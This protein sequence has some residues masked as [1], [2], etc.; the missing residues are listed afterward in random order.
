MMYE[1]KDRIRKMILEKYSDRYPRRLRQNQ[2]KEA[3]KIGD[4]DRE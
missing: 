1:N 2:K 4:S 3:T